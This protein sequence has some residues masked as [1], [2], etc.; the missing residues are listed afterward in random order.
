MDQEERLQYPSFTVRTALSD[1]DYRVRDQ[2]VQSIEDEDILF[3]VAREDLVST[4]RISAV[5][6]LRSQLNLGEIALKDPNSEVRVVAASKISDEDVLFDLWKKHKRDWWLRTVISRNI[7]NPAY[8]EEIIVGDDNIY[9]KRDTLQRIDDDK[10]LF[11]IALRC[12][13]SDPRISLRAVEKM[14]DIELLQTLRLMTGAELSNFANKCIKKL[15]KRRK[16]RS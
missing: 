11:N 14:Q 4:V 3:K 12:E 8:L 13:T 7:S 10:R 2:I 15:R 9:V 16:N 1:P 6:R 5:K